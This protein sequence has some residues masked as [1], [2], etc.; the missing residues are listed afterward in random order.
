MSRY[1]QVCATPSRVALALLC[2][3]AI[4]GWAATP[5]IVGP[6]PTV[7]PGGK[8]S[9][10]LPIVIRQTLSY[11]TADSIEIRFDPSTSYIP[12]TPTG[13]TYLYQAVWSFGDG[14]AAF[15]VP[16]AGPSADP[17]QAL[18]PVSGVFTYVPTNGQAVS[19]FTVN[20]RINVTVQIGAES[21]SGPSAFVDTV[22][23]FA[24]SNDFPTAVLVQTSSPATGALPYTLTVQAGL[25][26]DVDGYIIWAAID[27]GDGS[28]ERLTG[29]FPTDPPPEISHTY[30]QPGV[31]RVQLT[32]I[33]NGRLP[34]PTTDPALPAPSAYTDALLAYIA[35]QGPDTTQQ[36]RLDQDLL[37]VQVP[38]SMTTVKS[39][40][41]LD[42]Q[43]D[44]ND[45]FKA[46]FMPNIPVDSVVSADVTVSVGSLTFSA[47]R[48]DSR[49]RFS[50][51]GLKFAFNARRQRLSLK[52]SKRALAS[53]LGQTNTSIVNGGV[54][55][56]INVVIAGTTLPLATSIRYEYNS[57]KDKRGIGKN[58]VSSP[59]G[60]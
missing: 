47:F 43:N 9:E 11:P 44:N 31:Y 26:N 40:F 37:F 15:L 46:D 7:T 50:G 55:V 24:P 59:A 5:A 23:K 3:A 39:D 35:L 13:Q 34:F 6:V 54:N 36:S 49:G 30:T 51:L 27:W 56:P 52:I 20:F 41:K 38:G 10:V 45:R 18:Q 12:A 17:A 58:G 33:D 25:S 21:T 19:S 60:N 57:Q 2:A 29:P 16:A 42:F 28:A 22:V 8:G 1:S 53:A 32:T 4:S 48:T 14:T